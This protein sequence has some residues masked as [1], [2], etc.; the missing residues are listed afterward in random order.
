MV[1]LILTVFLAYTALAIYKCIFEFA[2]IQQYLWTPFLNTDKFYDDDAIDT[3]VPPYH[4]NASNMAAW[5]S[6]LTQ[7]TLLGSELCFLVIS[8]DLRLAYTNP[9]SSYKQNK[10]FFASIVFGISG[11]TS[12]ALIAMGDQVY[13]LSNIGIAWIQDRR[14]ALS[15]SYA[16]M[17]LFYF[18]L[19]A[20]FIYCLWANF[21]FN[22]KGFSR[23]VSNRISIM[24]RSKKYTVGY[25]IFGSV[26]LFLEF[27]SFCAAA[28][29]TAI[30]PIPA[31]FYCFRGVWALFVI[32]YSNWEELTWQQMNPFRFNM[33]EEKIA[34]NVAL[35][36]LL[37]QPHLNTALR[38]EILYFTTQGIMYAAREFE[39]LITVAHQSA[40]KK[41]KSRAVSKA[42]TAAMNSAD[43]AA[44]EKEDQQAADRRLDALIGP[45]EDRMYSFDDRLR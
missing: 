18:I 8:L 3:G 9:F 28:N 32:C 2:F 36:G 27:I 39:T 17:I 6:F 5:L 33:P 45:E 40:Q 7:F 21:N 44:E 42:A 12:M 38:A 41:R 15:P 31:Y 37:L 22:E 25:V 20:I 30:G 14:D 19:I 13:G 29:Q 43:R 34:E 4:C 16:K 24:R 10:L 23:T 35:E 1:D 11:A 26:V